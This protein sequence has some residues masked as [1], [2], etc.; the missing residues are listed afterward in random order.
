MADNVQGA[1]PETLKG[2]QTNI[3][4]MRLDIDKRFEALRAD[5]SRQFHSFAEEARKDRQKINGFMAVAHPRS[6]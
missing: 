4:Q 3:A 5:I 6:G 1:T 2:I